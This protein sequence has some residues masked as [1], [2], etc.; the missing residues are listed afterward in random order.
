MLDSPHGESDITAMR[1]LMILRHAKAER[2]GPGERDRD[3]KLAKRG[4]SD[5]PSIGAYM[6]RH[7]LVPDLALVSPAA[8]CQETWTL[9]AAAFAKTPKTI[10]DERLYNASAKRLIGVIAE[11]GSA[12]CILLV[13]HNPAMHDLAVELIASGEVE[14]RERVSE[15]LPTLGLVVID[16]ALDEWSQLHPHAGRLDRFISPRSIEVDTE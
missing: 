8:R 16:L 12:R 2:I 9:V 5:A 6:A 1:R 10:N 3:R 4:T 11:T 14:A 15:K 7:R 13:G